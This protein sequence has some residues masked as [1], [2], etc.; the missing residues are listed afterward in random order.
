MGVFNTVGSHTTFIQVQE[1]WVLSCL[2]APNSSFRPFVSLEELESP[3]VQ[4][5]SCAAPS[6]TETPPYIS[7]AGQLRETVQYSTLICG[8]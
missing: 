4:W 6:F 2:M 5:W 8:S 1:H 7:T 3:S